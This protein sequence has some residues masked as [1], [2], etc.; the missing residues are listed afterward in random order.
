MVNF[1]Y[2]KHQW[3]QY[4]WLIAILLAAFGIFRAGSLYTE[5]EQ[6]LKTIEDTARFSQEMV[7][8]HTEILEDLTGIDSSVTNLTDRINRCEKQIV[9]L[10]KE[11]EGK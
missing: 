2:V 8:L 10:H 6:N 7:K 9:Y 3:E 4:G 11:I 5:V 1:E